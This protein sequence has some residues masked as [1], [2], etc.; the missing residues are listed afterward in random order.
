MRGRNGCHV[1]AFSGAVVSAPLA[2]APSPPSSGPPCN[3]AGTLEVSYVCLGSVVAESANQFSG[4][5]V[6]K[7]C[8]LVE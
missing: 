6:A 8:C 3:D 2:T 1:D 4:H 5:W 7:S